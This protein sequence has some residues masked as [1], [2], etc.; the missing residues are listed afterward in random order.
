G[1]S[2]DNLKIRYIVKDKNRPDLF[3][4]TI[5]SNIFYPIP[6]RITNLIEKGMT[7][8]Q[9]ISI[10][11]AKSDRTSDFIAE[12]N[13]SYGD[14]NIRFF[15]DD[16]D[17]TS[18]VT[19]DGLSIEGIPSFGKRNLRVITTL[20]S[21]SAYTFE[22]N[23]VVKVKLH[24]YTKL[25]R[26]EFDIVFKVDDKG[27]PDVFI[28]SIHDGIYYPDPQNVTNKIEKGERITNYFYVQND[29]GD[30]SEFITIRGSMNTNSDWSYR[31]E[32]YLDGVWENISD[33]FTN[34]GYVVN[35][36]SG[37]VVTGRVVIYL[38]ASSHIPSGITNSVVVEALSQ[39]KLVRDLVTFKTIVVEPR[40]DLIAIPVSSGGSQTGGDFYESSISTVSAN[41]VSKGF[42]MLVQPSIYSILIENDDVVDDEIV[43]NVSGE[44]FVADKW[45][46]K[47]KNQNEEDVTLIMSNLGITNKIPGKRNIIYIVE[48]KLLNP[49][50]VLIGESNVVYFSVYSVKNTNK[51][52]FIKLVTT[53]IEVEISGKVVEKVSGSHI[54]GALIEVYESR[55]GN[56]AKTISSDNEG[57]FSVKLIPTTYKFI[58]K[59]DG[60]INLDKEITIPEVLEYTLE[61][62]ELL[63]FNLKDEVLD[64]HSF[65]NP[66][67]AGGKIKVLVNVPQKS[68]I[69]VLVMN[70]NG[71][72][73]KKFANGEEYEKGKYSFDWDLRADDGTTLKQGIYLLV[74]NNGREIIT[75]KV[76]VK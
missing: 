48:V 24:S 23:Y 14:W 51:V 59:K 55:T 72:I 64:M 75:K 32:L 76:M 9:E 10:F 12:A 70:M 31:I 22:S 26:D 71:T 8:T 62:F 42:V 15:L 28:S 40:P 1:I 61:N 11:N 50:N 20:A 44:L 19:A 66:V 63:R 52:D 38:G 43:V 45:Q 16:V 60:Y 2:N 4:S 46:V 6:Q 33:S 54:S 73:V 7:I 3:T 17:V 56:L 5:G 34:E 29:R 68:R 49:Y 13:G 58:V 18:Y 41:S 74:V 21:N 57:K 27:K 39:G 53:R 67:N 37:S 25:V 35:I 65:P 30:M 47:V 36:P 69:W